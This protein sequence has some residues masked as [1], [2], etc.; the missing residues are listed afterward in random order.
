MHTTVVRGKSEDISW[1]GERRIQRST[2]RYAFITYQSKQEAEDAKNA[3]NGQT[4]C[5][6]EIKVRL[7][8]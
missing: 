3:L 6:Q 1:W 4:V 2:A 7:Y 8:Q 5:G